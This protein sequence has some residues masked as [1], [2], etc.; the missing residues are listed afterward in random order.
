MLPAMP[1]NHLGTDLSVCQAISEKVVQSWLNRTDTCDRPLP[2]TRALLT[3]FAM[4]ALCRLHCLPTHKHFPVHPQPSV[5]MR[6]EP[7]GND[8]I[9]GSWP[10]P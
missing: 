6:T 4:Y 9:S 1:H 5:H 10:G 3:P 2:Y 8:N 7:S